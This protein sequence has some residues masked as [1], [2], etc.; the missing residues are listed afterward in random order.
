[1]PDIVPHISETSYKTPQTLTLTFSCLTITISFN[2]HHSFLLPT[3]TMLTGIDETENLARME[4]GDLYYAFT[5]QLTAE[6]QR[7]SRAV[8]RLNNAG[9]LTRRQM[10]ELWKEYVDLVV[11]DLTGG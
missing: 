5:P 11:S 7:C 10:A 9:D 6:R 1:M 4:R 8:N 2:L 3:I